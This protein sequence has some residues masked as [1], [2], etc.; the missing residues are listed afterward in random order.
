MGFGSAI[1]RLGDS[2]LKSPLSVEELIGHWTR[3][4]AVKRFST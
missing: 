1:N 4:P 3:N 2:R